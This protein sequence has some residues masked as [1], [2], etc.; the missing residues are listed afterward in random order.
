VL[1]KPKHLGV[2][3]AAQFKDQSIAEAYQNRPPYP[4][5][6]F[7]ILSKLITTEPRTVLDAG[8]GT[9]DVARPL[10]EFDQT[11][12]RIDAVDFSEAM[13]S[14]G[15]DLPGGT[16][17]RLNWIE[18]AIETAPL[19]PPYAL[20]TAGESLHWFD[21][22]KVF[23]LFQ[24]IL[25]PQGFVAVVGRSEHNSA[26]S[27]ELLKLIQKFSTNKD[28]QPYNTIDEISKRGLFHKVG[29]QHP[30]PVKFTQSIESYV[31]SIHSRN[32]FSRD[33]MTPEAAQAFDNQAR[34]LLSEYTQ[35][36]SLELY[37]IGSVTWGLPGRF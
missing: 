7:E 21:W 35:T 37:I 11:L 27:G 31:E 26:W 5:G 15:R 29:E 8:C 12:E 6:V 10:V 14:K 19:R 23:P 22:E 20:V 33:R 32:G 24:Q 18:S 25:V 4:A 16:N 1:P 13:L 9:G 3:Y 34:D 2:E 36:G 30:P 17:P 28:F